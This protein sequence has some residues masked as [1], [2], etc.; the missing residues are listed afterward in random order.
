MPTDSESDLLTEIATE[1]AKESEKEVAKES[2]KEIAKA[3]G[4]SHLGSASYSIDKI[5]KLIA[6]G[7]WKKEVK[8]LEKKLNLSIS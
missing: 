3:F 7:Q 5:K 2:Q 1:I 4:L 8:W 6:E